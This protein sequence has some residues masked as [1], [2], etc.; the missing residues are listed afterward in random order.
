M[1]LSAFTPPV[2]TGWSAT[3]STVEG[4]VAPAIRPSFVAMKRCASWLDTVRRFPPTAVLELSG[5]DQHWLS[6]TA[7]P[8]KQQIHHSNLTA[9]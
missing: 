3:H 2:F 6:E 9:N 5:F 1:A 4:N 8:D 7:D